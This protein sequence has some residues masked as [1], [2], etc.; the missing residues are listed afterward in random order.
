MFHSYFYLWSHIA[1]TFVISLWR[2]EINMANR[3]TS[4][5][6]GMGTIKSVEKTEE[7]YLVKVLFDDGLEKEFLSMVNP[8]TNKK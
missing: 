6:Y 5:I 1:D 7:G 3:I 2:G 4:P 8:L